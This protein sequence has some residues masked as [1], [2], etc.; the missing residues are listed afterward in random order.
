MAETYSPLYTN[1]YITKPPAKVRHAGVPLR[2]IDCGPY[3]QV[4]AGTAA[5]TLQLCKLPVGSCLWLHLC[6]LSFAGFTGSMTLSVGWG[7]YTDFDGA[8]QTASATGLW[9]AADI[10]NST[11]WIAAGMQVISTP[12]DQLG[13]VFYKDFRNATEV[14]LYATFN[15]QVPGANATLHAL[16]VYSNEA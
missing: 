7:A 14:Q 13:A 5:D 3:T 8:V 9:N 2:I 4:L 16:F 10:S 1:L 15:D 6:A 11:G 12:D